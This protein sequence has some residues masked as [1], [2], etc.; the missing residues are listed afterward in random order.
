MRRKRW[1][2]GLLA[3]AAILP[4]AI[5]SCSPTP[6]E[7]NV[8]GNGT[9]KRVLTSIAPLHCM[10]AN[11]AGSDAEVRCLLTS[12]GPHEY[13]STPHDA[14][15]LAGADLFI[16]N[17]F[18]LEDFLQSLVRSA[19]NNGLRVVRTSEHIE[20]VA[21]D[22]ILQASG[23]PHYHGDKLV[24]HTGPDPHVWLGVEEAKLQVDAIRDA[25]I[26]VDPAHQDGYRRRAD[27]FNQKLQALHDEFK[28]MKVPGGLV[29]FHDSFQYFGRSFGV[30]IEGTIRDLAGGEIP[31][32]KLREQAI[33][34][35]YKGVKLV[36]VEPQ[37][38]RRVA[39][40]LIREIGP[41]VRLIELDPIETGPAAEGRNYYLEPDYYLKKMRENL[42]NLKQAAT[43]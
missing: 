39:E 10:A 40:N 16:V 5:F 20:Q 15:L 14:K 7:E 2:A 24:R 23:V 31:P 9:K 38:P 21:K 3:L 6:R 28:D 43:K 18:G 30:K 35:R 34:F 29:T 12:R 26:A 11:I 33:E 41:D 36:S 1:L 8:W 32:A 22:R 37:Y 4:I 13:Q 17:G 25:L 19:G 27:E 42:E